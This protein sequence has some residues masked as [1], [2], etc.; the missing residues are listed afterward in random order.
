MSL[1]IS[2]Q[3]R[4]EGGEM[5]KSIFIFAVLTVIMSQNVWAS[6]IYPENYNFEDGLTHW[7][8]SGAYQDLYTAAGSPGG[9]NYAYISNHLEGPRSAATTTLTSEAIA[10]PLATSGPLYLHMWRQIVEYDGF[11]DNYAQI[12]LG[13]HVLEQTQDAPAWGYTSTGWGEVNYDIT[14]YAGQTLAVEVYL[15]RGATGS[16]SWEGSQAYID[17]VYV[18]DAAAPVPEP[19]TMLLLGSGLAGLAALRKRFRK[20]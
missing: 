2:S 8:V 10:I 12:R 6:A 19:T 3:I 1:L 16:W 5:K 11:A 7:T 18:H 9:G 17:D 13:S 20:A 4:G 14:A 15:Y